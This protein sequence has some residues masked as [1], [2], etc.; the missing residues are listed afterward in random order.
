MTLRTMIVAASS[1]AVAGT[2]AA[3]WTSNSQNTGNVAERTGRPAQTEA[4][5]TS[6]LTVVCVGRD[7]IVRSPAP[8]GECPPDHEELELEADEGIC[9]LC[10]PYGEPP[11]AP[12]RS[13]ELDAV[14]RRIWS[15]E[16]TP[17]FEVVDGRNSPIFRVGPG[18][19]RVFNREGKP[20]AAIGTS[21]T[22]GFFTARSTSMPTDAQIGVSGTTA[23]LRIQES[24]LVRV[25]L[26]V[27][28]KWAS[29]RF[30]S[31]IGL[32]AGL[33]ESTAGPGTLLLGTLPGR[34]K[35][36]FSVPDARGML[37]VVKKDDNLGGIALAEA[38]VGGGMLDLGEPGGQSAVKM[39]HNGHRYGIV[40]AGP[41]LG[42]PL[43]PKSGLPGSYFMGCASGE[44][45]ACVPE[46]GSV[47]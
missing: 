27:K 28:D 11:P 6:D 17:Y 46:V 22:G 21:E 10:D 45:P 34:V 42:L 26:T 2:A 16:N 7:R 19:V 30:P 18:G 35:V 12:S 37:S 8:D 15:L 44:R 40:L 41:V 14:E 29:L 32:I 47:K 36:T 39:G 3:W 33:G 1:M 25:D 9:E 31:A 24:G 13:R 20:Q 23:G 38:K 5:P 4:A 43:V